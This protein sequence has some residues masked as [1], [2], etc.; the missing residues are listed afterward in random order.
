MSNTTRL[1]IAIAIII[2]VAISFGAGYFVRAQIP[3]NY[4][5]G[6]DKIVEV[7]DHISKDYVS[8]SSVNT[9]NL[10]ASAIEGMLKA[11][12]DPYSAYLDKTD[13]ERFSTSLAGNYE[14]IGAY[15]SMDSGNVTIVSLI[16]GSPAEAAGL[17]SGD[18][19]K[20]VDGQSLEGMSLPEAIALIRGPE[21]TSV[22]L[23]IQRPSEA[24]PMEISIVRAK[25]EVPSVLLK[26]QGDIAV[27]T[28]TQFTKTTP[29][30]I[31]PII[32]QINAKASAKGI[33]L[34]LRNN[35]GGLLSAVVDVA[36]HFITSGLIVEVQS[37]YG[38]VA[39]Y[40]AE[41]LPDTTDLPMVVLVNHAS[42]SGAE[43]L[44]GALQDHQRAVIAGEVT[45]GKGSV[46]NLYRLDD[47]S[48]LYLTIMRWLTP[49]GRLIE[50][51]GITPNVP[52]TLTGQEELDW[53]VNQLNSG[54]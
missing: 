11:L 24:N 2:V 21:G 37:N 23:T 52:L 51:K 5:P 20:G 46:D 10:S 33:V 54:Q 25:L 48:G 15:V 12:N 29:D 26:W 42:A 36:S 22:N 44:S 17:M 45:Y 27:I 47:G 6:L 7:W 8:P 28:I 16:S 50:G 53:A 9:D 30:E 31:I 35:P 19:I 3:P 34:D 13:Y 41:N 4:S 43:V 14:G 49:N 18:I 38:T 1:F 32:Q 39:Q 40:K